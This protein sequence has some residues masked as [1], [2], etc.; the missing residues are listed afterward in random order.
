MCGINGIT[1]HNEELVSKMNEALRH[2]GPDA[3]AVWSEGRVTLGANRLA[4]IDLSPGAN[5]PISSPD[6][7]YTI[8]FNGEIYNYREL[9]EKLSYPFKTQGDTEVI[10]ALFQKEGTLAFNKLDGMFAI[11]IW[12][13]R[14]GELTLARDHSGIKPLY[15]WQKGDVLAF[16][17]E[18]KG[19][20][21]D[22]RIERKINRTVLE[23][24][25]RLRYVPEPDTL[26]EGVKKLPPASYAVFS[27]RTLRIEKY[28]EPRLASPSLLSHAE[29]VAKT[30]DLID[31]SV[32]R[33]LISDRPLGVFLSGGLD[34][35]IVL[36]AATKAGGT[37]ETF[38]LSFELSADEQAS[39]FNADAQLAAR[40]AKHY[41]SKHH[42][43]IFT[44]DEFVGL[45]P[46]AIHFL[47]QP[48]GNATALAQLAL[49]KKAREHIVVALHGDGGDELFGGYPRYRLSRLMDMYQR[50]PLL[51]RDAL[52][53]LSPKLAKLNTRAGIERVELFLFEKNT[54]LAR[55]V[56]NEFISNESAVWFKEQYLNGRGE[57]DCTQLLMDIDRRS[58]LVD[59]ALA[60]TDT[61]TMGA[62]LEARVPLLSP[63]IVSFASSLPTS[64]RVGLFQS[65][66]LLRDAY[67]K[68]LPQHILSAE[69]RGFFSPTAKWIRRPGLQAIAREA[70]SQ[71]FH[72]PTDGLLLPDAT[73]LL[74]AHVQGEY[75]VHTLWTL[76]TLRLWA[77]EFKMSL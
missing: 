40:S 8:V 49:A 71:G 75:A 26:V 28:Y 25:L 60:R 1:E 54:H 24:Y 72:A 76:V 12:D 67:A 52:S 17:S 69:K 64:A 39:K 42:E 43:V 4:I 23:R 30:G 48:I 34:S 11:A 14:K 2:R 27:N 53:R 35:T 20:L 63:D 16:S 38:S 51:V 10:L 33:Q 58:W 45:L 56:S 73:R 9:R 50:A 62:S 32:K 57:S 13:A 31:T 61:M 65:K 46:D 7:R 3:T 15:Y 47:D 22:V 21:E 37:M 55:A 59:E 68:R 19:L 74:D 77:K 18:V 44:E 5:Q 6:G 29:M 66:K 36:D 41:G 70:L